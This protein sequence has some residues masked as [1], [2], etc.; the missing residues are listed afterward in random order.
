MMARHPLFLVVLATAACGRGLPE[1]A[2]SL[3]GP[4]GELLIAEFDAAQERIDAAVYTF[5]DAAIAEALERAQDRGVAVR[6]VTDAAQ[7]ATLSGQQTIIARLT[8]SGL[9]LCARGGVSGGI[10]HHKYAVIDGR[11]VLTGSFNW[12]DAA[13]HRNAE[14]L[15]RIDDVLLADRY[16]TLHDG[17]W[18]CE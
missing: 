2:F 12:T 11:F 7:S 6:L 15:L 9:P 16:L 4:P 17:L 13:N 1:V 14:D 8:N 3:E 5:T 10:M 18:T